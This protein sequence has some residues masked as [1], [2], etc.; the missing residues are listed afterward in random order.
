MN[1]SVLLPIQPYWVFLIIAKAM[2][3]DY[4]KEKTVE[5]RKTYPKSEEWNRIVKLYCSKDKNSFSRI[6]KE[7]QPLMK[8]LLGKVVGE[9]MCDKIEGIAYRI[10]T[11]EDATGWQDRYYGYDFDF[12]YVDEHCLT[13]DELYSYG[14]KKMLFGWHISDLEIYDKPKELGEFY[15]LCRRN[16]TEDDAVC[17]NCPNLCF[18][19]DPLNGYTRWCGVNKRKPL[20]R[21]PQSWCYV[22]GT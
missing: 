10:Q 14:N 5:V 19:N 17:R 1:K 11:P 21:P 13:A 18:D 16:G 6:P 3:W 12:V 22:E 7:Y 9:F 4:P 8:E 15:T 20:T 2:G